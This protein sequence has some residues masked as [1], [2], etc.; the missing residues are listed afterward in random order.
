VENGKLQPST[1]Q[2]RSDPGTNTSQQT[3]CATDTPPVSMMHHLLD[4]QLRSL[5]SCC[6]CL[7][8]PKGSFF[9]K[10]QRDFHYFFSLW[11]KVI[12]KKI[13]WL[14]SFSD[15]FE[16]KKNEWKVSSYMWTELTTPLQILAQLDISAILW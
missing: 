15:N 13:G 8:D 9:S 14:I 12:I 1:T 10:F 3:G 2:L 5:K 16:D 7:C 4:S 11:N 6:S